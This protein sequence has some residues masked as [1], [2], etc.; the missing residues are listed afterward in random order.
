MLV[1]PN[2]INDFASLVIDCTT[3]AVHFPLDGLELGVVQACAAV[4][5][6][7]AGVST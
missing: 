6:A 7:N 5:A 4:H 1:G 2:D 3:V